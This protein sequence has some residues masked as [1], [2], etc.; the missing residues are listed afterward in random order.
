MEIWMIDRGNHCT[1]M[2]NSSGRSLK[3]IEDEADLPADMFNHR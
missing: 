1:V 2:T 3:A